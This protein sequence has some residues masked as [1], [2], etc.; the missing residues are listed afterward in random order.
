MN[1]SSEQKDANGNIIDLTKKKSNSKL[2]PSLDKYK[3]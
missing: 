3:N 1:G 2:L